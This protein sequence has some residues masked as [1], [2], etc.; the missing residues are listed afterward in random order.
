MKL[1]ILS[2][3]IDDNFKQAVSQMTTDVIYF[4]EPK[5]LSNFPDFQDEE[6]K[7]LVVD[8]DFV[9]WSVTKEA[10]E[11]LNNVKAILISSTSFS[12]LDQDALKSKN[13]PLINV[14]DWST[15]AVAE[16]STM[17]AFNLARKIPLL[18]KNQFELSYEKY[19]G[20]QL[21]GKTAGIIGM[22]NIGKAVAQRAKGLGMNVIYWSKNST[23]VDGE[24]VSL[25]DV[26]SQADFLFP[27]MAD[28]SETQ[29]IITDQLLMSM[30]SSSIFV[31]IVHKYYN[32]DLLLS[33]VKENKLFGYGFEDS[34][35]K[36][37]DFEGNVWVAPE[38]AWCTKESFENNDAKLLQN[39]KNALESNFTGK[40][41]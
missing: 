31:S 23:T 21:K 14:K 12:W 16:W 11:G 2:N 32:H 25:E 35:V 10:I 1:Y 41:N 4:T 7:L 9:D 24:L 36:L 26:F 28:N 40:V 8:P 29:K 18:I 39:I 27:T 20:V 34:K 37:T 17:M 22:G 33:M 13:I 5:A 38:Y 15:Q 3:L 30:K 6:E 19:A